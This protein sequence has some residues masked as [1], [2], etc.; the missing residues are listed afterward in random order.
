MNLTEEGKDSTSPSKKERDSTVSPT[1]RATRILQFSPVTTGDDASVSKVKQ[2]QFVY[3][4]L[5]LNRYSHSSKVNAEEFLKNLLRQRGYPSVKSPAINSEYKR[6]IR[7]I[8]M[9]SYTKSLIVA[10]GDNDF[11]KLID[12]YKEQHH[13]LACNRFGEST[14]HLA[15][16][17]SSHR[18]VRFILEVEDSPIMID[19]YGRSALTDAMWAVTPSF[20]VIELLMSK[21]PE[22]I[23]LV[24]VRGFTPL[25]YVR[26][27]HVFKVCLFLYSKRDQ[28]WPLT[29]GCQENVNN[30]T[31]STA[32]QKR[33]LHRDTEETESRDVIHPPIKKGTGVLDDFSFHSL[34]TAK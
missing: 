24:D 9:E 15:A 17:K 21:Y 33:K 28:Y 1:S 25:S 14:L 11:S 7:P 22:L 29:G 12:I 27:E 13:L 32:G 8:E 16:R 34:A 3:E 5:G 31:M 19:D 10:I 30:A 18:V 23:S 4:T 6:P 2:Y 26:Q 20:A